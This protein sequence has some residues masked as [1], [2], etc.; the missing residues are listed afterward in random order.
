MQRAMTQT[1]QQQ[2]KSAYEL[3]KHDLTTFKHVVRIGPR[4]LHAPH[5]GAM[6]RIFT[7]MSRHAETDGKFGIGRVIIEMP[8]RHG[9]TFTASQRWPAWHLGRNPYH[10]VMLVSYAISLARKS[11][12]RIR[13]MI[14][15]QHYQAVFPGVYLNP[16]SQSVDEWDMDNTEG[17]CVAT[18][19]LGGALGKGANILAIDDPFKG[20]SEAESEVIREKVWDE[21]TDTFYPRLEPGGVV[22]VMMQRFHQDDLAGRLL[23]EDGWLELRLPA[24]AEENDM[25]GRAVDEPLWPDRWGYDYLDDLRRRRGPYTWASIY[26]QNPIPAE[27]G[28]FRRKWFVNDNHPFL[29]PAN[30]PPMVHTVRYWD[31]A[32]SGKDTADYS[33]GTKYGIDAESN[34]YVLDVKRRRLEWG[35]VVPWMAEVIESDGQQVIQGIEQAAFMTRAITELNRDRRFDRY[36][37][38]GYP[39]HKDKVTNA[40]PF[41]AKAAA[42]IVYLVQ[43]LWNEPWL[44]EVCAFNQAAHDDQVDSV[45]GAEE[46]IA[47]G[48]GTGAGAMHYADDPG[49]SDGAG[50]DPIFGNTDY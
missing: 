8:P 18:G 49:F 11:S 14:K 34:R 5:I 39:K 47:S 32:M 1:R 17:G 42:G 12:R 50:H 22:M 41:A 7:Q 29:N 10:R 33:V 43:G 15:S 48:A 45:A 20:R 25:L 13:D 36:Q 30:L 37:I 4:Y 26:Q 28:I 24:L 44:E 38:L 9:K 2:I 21:Y 35:D 27:G 3:A 16:K 6:D 19:M 23:K 31:L 46:M 40:L